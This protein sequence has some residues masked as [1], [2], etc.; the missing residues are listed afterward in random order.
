[1]IL[2][3]TAN[4][5]VGPHR[6]AGRKLKR[7]KVIR[8]DSVISQ[9]GGKGVQHRPR[10][11]RRRRAGDRGAARGQGQTLSCSSCSPRASTAARCPTT[12]RCASTSRSPS[13]TATTTKLNSPG[14]E[15]TE[16]VRP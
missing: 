4:P 14:P 9:A 5:S 15:L 12:A 7:G 10:L 13:P 1:M 3:L 8:A 11:H 16:G 2:T 6:R